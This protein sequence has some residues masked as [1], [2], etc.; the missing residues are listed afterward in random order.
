MISEKTLS[1]V[2]LSFDSLCLTT[3]I[4]I[5]FGVDHQIGARCVLRDMK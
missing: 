3:A 2:A 4:D 1:I 5:E